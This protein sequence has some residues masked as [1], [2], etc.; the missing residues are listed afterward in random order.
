MMQFAAFVCSRMGDNLMATFQMNKL[1]L[2]FAP[3]IFLSG[4][5]VIGLA[6]Y[7]NAATTWDAGGGT[8]WWYNPTN[9]SVDLL[10]PNNATGAATDTQINIG[11]GAWDLGEGVVYDPSTN[12][13]GFTAAQSASYPSGF[14]AQT[15]RELYISRNTPNTNKLTIKGNLTLLERWHIGRSSGTRGLGTTGIVVQESGTVT[16]TVRETDLGQ[17]DTSNVGYGNGT[18]DYRSGIL[19]IGTTGGNGLRLSVGSNSASAD[20]LKAGPAGVGKFI[21]HSPATPGRIRVKSLTSAQFAGFQ[22]GV[23]PDGS[24]SVFDAQFDANGVTTGVSIFEF[25]YANGGTRPIQV[26]EGMSINNGV[27]QTTRGIRSSRLDF[28]VDQAACAGASCVPNNVGLF[29]IDFDG[30]GF[31]L[32]GAGDLNGNNV[33]NDDRVFSNLSDTADYREGDMVS[34]TFGSTQYNWTISYSGNIS[35]TNANDSVVS[36]ITGMG[37]GSDIVLMGHSSVSVGIPG[38][39]DNDSDVD[40]RDFLVWQRNTSVGNLSD[41]QTNYGTGTGPLTAVT[42]VPEPGS[43]A[44][45][46]ALVLPLFGRRRW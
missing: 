10:P 31:V 3:R 30:N 18:Y 46:A 19:D 39:F 23:L 7:A 6:L 34:A 5:V 12:D 22:E 41:W 21:V 28:V 8:R 35:W 24:D 32:L 17:V 42:A 33:Y 29:D 27:D 11:T 40:G 15:I 2:A 44:L 25:H 4:L 20:A 26:R 43:L 14:G 45:V 1:G 16:Q 13:P 36:S 9:W 38:D 37:T